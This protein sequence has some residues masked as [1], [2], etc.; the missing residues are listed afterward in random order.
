[1]GSLGE[2]HISWISRDDFGWTSK[3]SNQPSSMAFPKFLPG[4]RPP[5]QL[6]H[7][8]DSR[9]SGMAVVWGKWGSP[10]LLLEGFF[11]VEFPYLKWWIF[12]GFL[13]T[14][15]M[16]FC[17]AKEDIWYFFSLLF[18]GNEQ[19]GWPFSL[20]F[21]G[22]NEQTGWRLSTFTSIWWTALR[23]LR[24][25][26]GF[27]SKHDMSVTR[28]SCHS[29]FWGEQICGEKRGVP[30]RWLFHPLEMVSIGAMTL[31]GSGPI[32]ARHSTEVSGW[33]FCREFGLSEI[34][35]ENWKFNIA[36]ENRPSP[37]KSSLPTTIFQK[38]C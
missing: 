2:Y 22:A 28:P 9:G 25:M 30:A 8:R 36:P 12:T 35:V 10:P 29:G 15:V 31:T 7:Q 16:S 11:F 24:I 37:Y 23:P 14:L 20:L 26:Q 32:D 17:W 33:P 19:P 34:L 38:L 3:G 18:W 4:T 5:K 13:P 1:M 6:G 21:W 27:R